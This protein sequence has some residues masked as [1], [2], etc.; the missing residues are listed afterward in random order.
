MEKSFREG[1]SEGLMSGTLTTVVWCLLESRLE[2]WCTHGHS[3][4]DLT[5]LALQAS[6]QV[7]TRFHVGEAFRLKTTKIKITHRLDGAGSVHTK[8]LSEDNL[9]GFLMET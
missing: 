5:P 3:E 8:I 2:F 1:K 7:K 9:F 6:S 4:W